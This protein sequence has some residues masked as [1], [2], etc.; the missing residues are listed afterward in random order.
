MGNVGLKIP[1]V[2]QATEISC[3]RKIG[4]FMIGI[5]LSC[6]FRRIWFETTSINWESVPPTR[7][8]IHFAG[9]GRR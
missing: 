4:R 5:G 3:C 2:H 8:L 9:R 1:A 6:R 7:F